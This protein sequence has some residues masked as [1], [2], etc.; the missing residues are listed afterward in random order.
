[1]G[2]HEVS[3]LIWH[4]S[5]DNPLQAGGVYGVDVSTLLYAILACVSVYRRLHRSPAASVQ[6]EVAAWLDEW[7]EV[8]GFEKLDTKL[9]FV[10]DGWELGLKRTRRALRE[11]Q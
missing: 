7:F 5:D 1:M 8:H 11:V 4:P 10:F 3:P 6:H 9:I 2:V